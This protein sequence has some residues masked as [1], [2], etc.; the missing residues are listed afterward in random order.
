MSDETETPEVV[1][2]VDVATDATGDEGANATETETEEAKEQPKSKGFQ[3]RIDDLV[4]RLRETERRLDMALTRSQPTEPA[5][6][7]EPTYYDPGDVSEQ[8]IEARVRSVI[9]QEQEAA[10]LND[11]RSSFSARIGETEGGRNLLTDTTIP[12]TQQA[13]EVLS[14][15]ENGVA[16]ADYLG[17]NRAEAQ[18]LAAVPSH[19]QAYELGKLE[20]R[21]TAPPK[22]KPTTSAPAP[23]E[24]VGAR[25]SVEA[26]PAKMSTDDW[27]KWRQSQLKGR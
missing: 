24:P 18:R 26:D 16:V 22:P 3:K 1:D 5:Y 13:L 21:L 14:G 23:F 19:L 15:S 25:G 17:R 8:A 12:F 27:M 7:P 10:R 20:A 11:L 4:Y 9:K 2:P 6:E